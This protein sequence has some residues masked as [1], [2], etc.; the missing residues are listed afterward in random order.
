MT[1]PTEPPKN[2]NSTAGRMALRRFERAKLG[3]RAFIFSSSEMSDGTKI[4]L[5]HIV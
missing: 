3:L 5:F 2:K 1:E 4:R